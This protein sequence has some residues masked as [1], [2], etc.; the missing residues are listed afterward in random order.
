VFHNN[1]SIMPQARRHAN[2]DVALRSDVVPCGDEL[3]RARRADCGIR[4]IPY[5]ATPHR[6]IPSAS[7]RVRMKFP[8]PAQP[9]PHSPTVRVF[10]F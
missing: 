4:R 6:A 1:R 2:R 7:I 10:S 3:R 8:C 5:I 9:H